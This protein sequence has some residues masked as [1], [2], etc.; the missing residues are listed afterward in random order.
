MRIFTTL[1]IILTIFSLAGCKSTEAGISTTPQPEPA[2]VGLSGERFTSSDGFYSFLLPDEWELSEET[3]GFVRISAP[4]SDGYAPNLVTSQAEDRTVLE[5]WA[6]TFRDAIITTM[7]GYS[8]ISED[9]LKSDAR[10]MFYRWEATST[11]Q[12]LNY[13]HVFYLFE[14]DA[15]KLVILYTRLED[16]GAEWDDAVDASMRS[17]LFSRY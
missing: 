13:H 16:A 5:F 8:Q 7:E 12:G 14:S 2:Q 6:I 4:T 10:E 1:A 15:W 11:Q 17:V 3:S 9:F